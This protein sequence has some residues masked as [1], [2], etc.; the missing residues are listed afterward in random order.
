M[1]VSEFENPRSVEEVVL[2]LLSDGRCRGVTV[3]DLARQYRD[4]TIGW[5][6]AAVYDAVLRASAEIREHVAAGMKQAMLA[7]GIDDVRQKAVLASVLDTDLSGIEGDGSFAPSPA[8]CRAYD[9]A[10]GGL[11]RMVGRAVR[12]NELADE[13]RVVLVMEA[14]FLREEVPLEIRITDGGQFMPAHCE[15]IVQHLMVNPSASSEFLALLAIEIRDFLNSGGRIEGSWGSI[16][17]DGQDLVYH[18]TAREKIA[19]QKSKA[20]VLDIEL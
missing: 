10:L 20:K 16:R 17:V 8:L 2:S 15:K 4:G 9:R 7:A 13:V 5:T 14:R 19:Y 11:S 12:W 18:L 6:E 1:P 3:A